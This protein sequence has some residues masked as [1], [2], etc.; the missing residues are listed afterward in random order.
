MD[1]RQLLLQQHAWVHARAV[2]GA[3]FSMEESVTRDLTD[4]QLRTRPGP[5]LNSIAW[6][7]WHLSR[8]EDVVV[9]TILRGEP[10]VLDREGWLDRL[11]VSTRHVGTSSQDEEVDDFGRLVDVAALRAYRAAVGRETRAWLERVDLA[12]LERVPD[13]EARLAAAPRTL[14]ERA[15]WL[16]RFYAG[17]DGYFFVAFPIVD[18]GYLHLGEALVTRGQLGARVL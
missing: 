17:R 10:E 14:A 16:R 8:L 11:G 7:F 3:D 6:I 5:G 18:H 4:E 15:G 9:N 13:L 2:S 1:V 12:E